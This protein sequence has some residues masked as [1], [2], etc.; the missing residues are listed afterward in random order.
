MASPLIKLLSQEAKLERQLA[1]VR[2]KIK[3]KWLRLEN[4][5]PPGFSI[6]MDEEEIKAETGKETGNDRKSDARFML[7]MARRLEQDKDL[8]PWR[9]AS[10]VAARRPNS[11]LWN[12]SWTLIDVQPYHNALAKRLYRKFQTESGKKIPLYVP[13]MCGVARK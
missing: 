6:V 2:G 13:H 3:E 5:T 8:K 7:E 12:A 10:M 1:L 9:V 4:A 11:S